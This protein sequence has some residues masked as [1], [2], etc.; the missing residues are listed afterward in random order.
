MEYAIYRNWTL[1][2]EYLFVDLGKN[3]F[4]QRPTN[5]IGVG[6]QSTIN[7]SFTNTEFNLVRAGVNYRF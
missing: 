3:T 7:T 1:K 6:A 4:L 5:A 2:A